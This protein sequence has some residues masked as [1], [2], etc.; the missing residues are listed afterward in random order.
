MA[1]RELDTPYLMLDLDQL[2]RNIT[3]MALFAKENGLLLRPHAKTHK[4]PK[5]ARRQLAE[6]AAGLTVAKLGEAEVFADHGVTDIFI[7]YPVVGELKIE[8]LLQLAKRVHVRTIVDDEESA[9]ALSKAFVAAGMKLTVRIK[10]DTGMGRCGVKPGGPAL[11]LARQVTAMPGLQLEGITT[12]AGHIYGAATR[13]EQRTIGRAE[14]EQMVRTAELLRAK[15]IPVSV[16]SVGATPSVTISGKVKGVTEIRPGNYVFYDGIQVGLGVAS[17]K[18]CALRVVT[19]V[20]SR[21]TPSQVLVDGGSKTFC[22]DQG[23]HGLNVVKGYGYIVGQPDTVLNRLSE[24]HGFLQLGP[25]SGPLRLGETIEVIPNHACTVVNN[26][27]RIH[28]FHEGTL[29][30]LW[31]VAAQGKLQ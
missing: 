14:G 12:H 23:A 17:W 4:C 7:A 24:E 10:V 1:Q 16:V 18:Q 5:I 15:G 9:L 20:I 21:P 2:N 31:P 28:V 3:H 8:R 19:Q 11:A 29:I 6:G 25:K 26:F 22:L 27:D 13:E 30:G